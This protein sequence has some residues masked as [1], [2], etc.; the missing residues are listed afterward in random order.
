MKRKTMNTQQSMTSYMSSSFNKIAGLLM[1]LLFVSPLF[2]QDPQ[3]DYQEEVTIIGSYAPTITDAYKINF[4]PQIE[5]EKFELPELTYSISPVQLNTSIELEKIRPARMTG[6]PLSKLYHNYIKAGFGNYG[7]PYGEFFINSLRNEETQFG[8]HL[9][10]HSSNSALKDYKYSTFSNNLAEAW[11][12]K[13]FRR[14]TLSTR[15]FYKRNVVHYYGIMPELMDSLNFEK[16]DLKQRFQTIG[17][18][19]S[20]KSN[21]TD[22]DK[23]GHNIGLKYYNIADF[24]ET[25][26]HGF[27]FNAGLHKGAELFDDYSS[28]FGLDLGLD[29]FSLSDSIESNS[30]GVFRIHPYADL[31]FGI[32][33]LQLGFTTAFGLDSNNKVD[34]FPDIRGMVNIVPRYLTAFVGFTGGIEKSSFRKLA[35]EN[36][37]ITSIIPVAYTKNKMELYGGITGN[38]M[39]V[40][41]YTVRVG[42]ASYEN[43][44]FFVAASAGSQDTLNNAFSTKYDDASMM[45]ARFE[46]AYRHTEKLRLQLTADYYN[47]STDSISEAYY[48]PQYKVRLGAD[49]NI[50]NKILL[51]GEMIA[52]GKMHARVPDPQAGDYVEEIDGWL[53]INL[54]VE[55]RYTKNLSFFAN[56]N[57]IGNTQYLRWYNY[58]V[59]KFNILG[60]VTYSF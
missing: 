58:P 39:E 31:N 23:L 11:F 32:Y 28:T 36:P 57:N 49:Y 10:H 26:E 17:L 18:D 14:H 42:S 48:K 21:Y 15:A 24:Y 30:D 56:L 19:A 1:L 35:E 51:S 50:G 22:P 46:I 34:F 13:F 38:I 37:F 54:G 9:R 20:F 8:L 5:G 47:Y 53:D 7:T 59:Q 60:G 4:N 52:Y 45:N 41:D 55:F 6:E 29:Y 25:S 3:S 44:P 2:A 33:Q 16:D 43:M 40:V 12:K 27:T